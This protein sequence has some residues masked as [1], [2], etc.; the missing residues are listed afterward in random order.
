[1][2]SQPHPQ[3]LLSHHSNSASI[4]M[5]AGVAPQA[6]N[7]PPRT[8]FLLPDTL[9]DEGMV[10]PN[11]FKVIVTKCPMGYHEGTAAVS[12]DRWNGLWQTLPPVFLDSAYRATSNIPITAL[13]LKKH[14]LTGLPDNFSQL[15]QCL[16]V[17]DLS[18]NCFREFPSVVCKLKCLR[19]LDMSSNSLSAL[20]QSLSLLVNLRIL[21]FQ[22]NSFKSFP[23]VICHLPLLEI[24][25]ME[26]NGLVSLSDKLDQLTELKELYLRSNQIEWIPSSLCHLAHLETLHLSDNHLQ[27]LPTN[28]C[29]L[30]DLKQL[31]LAKNK[32][33]HL[34]VS[35]I[36]LNQLKGLTLG[37]NPL[38]YPPPSIWKK[39]LDHILKYLKDSKW[40]SVGDENEPQYE[41]ITAQDDNY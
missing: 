26:C 29:N 19:E 27:E 10:D 28:I 24:L 35:L 4:I 39:G 30:T 12:L 41:Q 15:S 1:M 33:K 34:P 25:N 32:L 16:T 5:A 9:N 7:N 23:Q 6:N 37:Q 18:G 21:N 8:P 36:Q 40:D 13:I 11:W 3:Y 2:Q 22:C 31:H 17:I 14:K 38:T 20:P